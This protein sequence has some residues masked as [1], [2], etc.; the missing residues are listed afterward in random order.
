MDSLLCTSVGWWGLAALLHHWGPDSKPFRIPFRYLLNW[1]LSNWRYLPF[2]ANLLGLAEVFISGENLV[3]N[4]FT[5]AFIAARK[6]IQVVV[7]IVAAKHLLSISQYLLTIGPI[8][9]YDNALVLHRRYLR[10]GFCDWFNNFLN[11][12]WVLCNFEICRGGFNFYRCLPGLYE[13][14]NF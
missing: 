14:D 11:P 12:C 5:R 8:R 2:L 10:R 9:W 4:F 13:V 1:E 6:L 3:K 7:D